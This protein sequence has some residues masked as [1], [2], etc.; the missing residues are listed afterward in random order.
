MRELVDNKINVHFRPSAP[1]CYVEAFPQTAFEGQ[2]AAAVDPAAVALVP[3]PGTSRIS[4][5]TEIAPQRARAPRHGKQR[6]AS[7]AHWKKCR[8]RSAHTTGR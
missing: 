3:S 1:C 6:R 5:R 7:A 8:I 2:Q 4:R